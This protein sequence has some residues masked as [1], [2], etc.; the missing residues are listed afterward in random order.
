MSKDLEMLLRTTYFGTLMMLVS[1]FIEHIPFFIRIMHK[2]ALLIFHHHIWNDSTQT[3]QQN[4][5]LMEAPLSLE[6]EVSTSP[7][8][9]IKTTGASVA[10]NALVNVLVLPPGQP[11][12]QLSSMT[13][14]STSLLDQHVH[15]WQTNPHYTHYC[16]SFHDSFLVVIAGDQV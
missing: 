3:S 5:A 8:C 14:V 12:V 9:T 4:P 15:A 7:R 10:V 13:M 2:L 1:F 6:L 16:C 11:P